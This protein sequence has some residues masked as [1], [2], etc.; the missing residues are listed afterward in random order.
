[1]NQRK[2]QKLFKQVF[3]KSI[4]QFALTLKMQKA[5]NLLQTKKYPVSE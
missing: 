2:L 1:M 3:G 5:R 4:Y